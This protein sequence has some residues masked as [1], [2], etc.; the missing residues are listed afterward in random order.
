MP[1]FDNKLFVDLSEREAKVLNCGI[2]LNIF[3]NAVNS[4]CGHTF[5]KDCIQQWIQS[6]HKE[7]PECRKRF[8]SILS[9]YGMSNSD[10]LVIISNYVFVRNLRI[11]S[12]VS[13]L[14]TKCEFN[15]CQQTIELGLLSGHMK[16]CEHRLCEKCGFGVGSDGQHNCFE[17]M[18]TDRNEWKEKWNQMKGKN[19][20]LEEEVERIKNE[21]TEQTINGLK[22][23][24]S[25]LEEEIQELSE[26]MVSSSKQMLIKSRFTDYILFGCFQYNIKR[27]K[28]KTNSVKIRVNSRMSENSSKDNDI[29]IE[30]DMKIPFVEI[31]EFKYCSDPTLPAIVIKPNAETYHKLQNVMYLANKS[32]KFELN[33][34]G[35]SISC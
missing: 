14:K 13:E 6:D 26:V 10:S 31:Q 15:G 11:N 25:K 29:D 33:S 28:L 21:K 17:L 7:C 27:L 3:D 24:I 4:E 19:Q 30:Y 22:D 2:C 12:M 9:T 16:E 18:M 35:K 34:E 32:V 5:C 23:K 8:R 20:K 1:G